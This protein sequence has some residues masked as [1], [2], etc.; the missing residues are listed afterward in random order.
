MRSSPGSTL[1]FPV[2]MTRTLRSRV[3]SAAQALLE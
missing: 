2:E 3:L 1:A